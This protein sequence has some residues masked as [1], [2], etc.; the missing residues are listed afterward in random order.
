MKKCQIIGVFCA[1]LIIPDSLWGKDE[2]EQHPALP[3]FDELFELVRE[4][5]KSLKPDQLNQA[6]VRGLLDHLSSEVLL[7]T[8]RPPTQAEAP[9][10]L[11][12]TNSIYEGTFGY[13]RMGR[14]DSGAASQAKETFQKLLST[15]SLKGLV[16]DLRFCTGH[17]YSEAAQV[18]DLF[19]GE[20]KVLLELGADA[21]RSTAKSAPISVP[22]VVLVNEQTA[23]AAEALAAVMRHSAASLIIGKLTAGRARTFQ[24]FTLKSGQKVKLAI[25]K[26]RLADTNE[27][28]MAGVVPDINVSVSS[29]EELAYLADPYR[30]VPKRPSLTQAEVGGTNGVNRS[31]R[32]RNESELIRLRREGLDLDAELPDS[33]PDTPPKPVLHDPALARA[34]DFLKGLAVVQNRK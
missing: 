26:V 34:V 1:L 10:Q 14:I 18:A 19:M 15:N 12:A 11:V 32:P 4:N 16:L 20:E 8:N 17:D 23:G 28:S 9:A 7:V 24:E 22:A 2:P 27:I 31:R 13:V 30:L 25:G 3:A 21:L 29:E 33:T 6:A 5:V